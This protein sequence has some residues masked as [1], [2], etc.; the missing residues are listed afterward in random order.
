[1]ADAT[2]A[3]SSQYLTFKLDDE[4]FTVNVHSVREILEYVKI[5]KMPDAPPFMRGIINVRGSIIPVIDLRRKF[6]I[7]ET[8]AR[9]T[10]R[11]IVLEID[12][13]EGGLVIGALADSVKEVIEMAVE[14]IEPPPDMG[15]RWK[16]D[17]ISGVGKHNEEFIMVLDTRKLF[18]A[19]ELTQID[20]DAD[21]EPEQC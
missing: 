21:A 15:T 5:T 17:Y 11:I 16:K 10:T 8:D 6:G 18:S 12:R 4:F 2:V 3:E 9:Q 13:E 14:Q 20:G 7:G 1:M 19:S